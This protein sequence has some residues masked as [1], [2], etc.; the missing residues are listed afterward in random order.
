MSKFS[1]MKL[2]GKLAVG[3]TTV[4]ASIAAGGAAFAYFTNTGGTGSGSATTTALATRNVTVT[5][6][7]SGLTYDGS[8]SA[9]S[10]SVS[11]ANPY[12]VDVAGVTVS[13]N[14]TETT[15]VH[16]WKDAGCPTD[17]FQLTGTLANAPYI[18]DASGG[19]HATRDI[20]GSLAIKF[21][22]NSSED[23]TGCIGFS[24]PLSTSNT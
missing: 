2:R 20:S 9:L 22:N 6:G 24:V 19:A 4:A 12:S 10:V 7:A 14:T 13:I 3:A 16:P 21:V 15:D 23:Q 17:S 1:N 18:L 8:T 5:A 11:N